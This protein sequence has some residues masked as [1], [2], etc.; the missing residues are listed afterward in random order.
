MSV[1]SFFPEIK[2]ITAKPILTM[3]YT[4]MS[5]GKVGRAKYE[6]VILLLFFERHRGDTYQELPS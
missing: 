5:G 2:R 1:I 6:N 4:C 3:N